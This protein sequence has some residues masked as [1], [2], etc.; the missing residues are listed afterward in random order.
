MDPGISEQDA[1]RAEIA[2]IQWVY[3]ARDGRPA[4]HAA[5]VSAYRLINED[6]HRR[7]RALVERLVPG[8]DRPLLDVGCGNG[9]DLGQWR[10]SGW[11]ADQLAGC[12]VVPD[13]VEAARRR[14]P[15]VDIRL[16]DGVTLPFPE[17]SFA[18]AT[19]VTVFSSILDTDTRRRLFAE[20]QRVVRPGG[21]VLVYDFV[22]RNPRNPA[23]LSMTAARLRELGRPPTSSRRMTPL[24][25]AV[26]AGAAV[27][28]RLAALAMR[29]APPTHRLAIW[30]TP[31]S[32]D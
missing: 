7:M 28:P 27:H 11:A 29:L 8:P 6:R 3:A 4:R 14:C 26:A 2:R 25:Y 32:A 31:V 19:A 17:G 23:V 21:L 18:V 12:D 1:S 5:I 16:G 20:M 15:D 10:L 22:V 30:R 24:V 9:W 13:R